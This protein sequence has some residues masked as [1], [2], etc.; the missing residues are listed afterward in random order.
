MRRT[1]TPS[2]LSSRLVDYLVER[3]NLSQ[4]DIAQIIGVD[5]SFVSRVRTGERELSPS[6]MDMIAEHLRVPLGAMLIDATEPRKPA[7]KDKQALLEMCDRL[8]READTA[9]EALATD[10]SVAR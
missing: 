8:M 1:R 7:S 2:A 10:R 6:Q 3:R 4:S 9:A 5:K